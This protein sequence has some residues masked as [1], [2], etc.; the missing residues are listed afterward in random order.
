MKIC[1]TLKKLSSSLFNLGYLFFSSFN[2][3]A[4]EKVHKLGTCFIAVHGFEIY[5]VETAKK[6][7]NCTR[8]TCA[9]G[10]GKDEDTLF[11]TLTCHENTLFFEKV[12][13]K[14]YSFFSAHSIVANVNVK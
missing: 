2:F 11:L 13:R 4:K 6:A 3:V 7:G 5:N 1:R 14:V 8:L 9:A 10:Q 12:R